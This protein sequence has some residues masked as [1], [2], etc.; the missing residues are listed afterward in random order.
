MLEIPAIK[1]PRKKAY[2]LKS[3][4]SVFF[5]SIVSLSTNAKVMVYFF[6][7]KKGFTF[8]KINIKQEI[9]H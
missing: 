8:V 2:T 3:S 1:P 7:T 4:T 9:S 5:L 6:I